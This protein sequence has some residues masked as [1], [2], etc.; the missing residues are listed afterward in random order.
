VGR[1]AFTELL[2]RTKLVGKFVREGMG[3]VIEI[4]FEIGPRNLDPDFKIK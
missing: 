4:R 1:A 2:R 3:E